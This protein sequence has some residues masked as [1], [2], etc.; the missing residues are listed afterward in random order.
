[1][2]NQ[3]L[4]IALFL[5]IGIIFCSSISYGQTIY[6]EEKATYD[7]VKYIEV[8]GSFCDVEIVGEDRS[9]VEF[10]GV[11]KGSSSKKKEFKIIHELNGSSLN[12]WIDRPNYIRGN[13][14]GTLELIVP[15][16]IELV[17]KNGSGDVYC[18]NMIADVT[19]LSASSGDMDIKNMTGDLY[20]TTTSGDIEVGKITGQL[21]TQSSSGDQE[22][23]TVDGNV[24]AKATS[25]SIEL[26]NVVGD[27]NSRTSSG[28]L[29]I[30]NIN[31]KFKNVSTS[32][33][34]EISNSRCYLNLSASSG[35]IEGKNVVLLGESYFNT[36]SGNIRMY[37]KNDFDQ[38]SFDLKASS[39]DLRAGNKEA[40]DQLYMKNGEIWVHGK[41]SSGD[42]VYQ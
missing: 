31:G 27:I 13:I 36:T 4:G 12:I 18:R 22:I 34:L 35:D 23:N 2:K 5:F 42:Q 19:K 14:D 26:S 1:M 16:D 40:E 20:L 10:E 33:N 25:G 30:D 28:D 6:A 41:S 37:L 29:E 24:S 32:G 39:G 11:I 38:L 8:K 3:K 15:K 21:T 7:G 9:N 17:V